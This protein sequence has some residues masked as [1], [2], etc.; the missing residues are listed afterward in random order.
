MTD[1]IDEKPFRMRRLSIVPSTQTIPEETVANPTI[2]NLVTTNPVTHPDV[3][4]DTLRP[5][6]ADYRPRRRSSTSVIPIIAKNQL[7]I[8]IKDIR[9]K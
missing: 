4:P 9:Q 3:V 7:D 5:P 1:H 6:P 8:P 2:S